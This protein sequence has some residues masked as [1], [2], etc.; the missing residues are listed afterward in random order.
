M[1]MDW[2]TPPR[3]VLKAGT[4]EVR[5]VREPDETG[6]GHA[7]DGSAPPVS[8]GEAQ[9]LP[10]FSVPLAVLAKRGP[11]ALGKAKRRGWRLLVDE[12][13]TVKLVDHINKTGVASMSSG[14]ALDHL[15]AAGEK[16]A[17]EIEADEA[18]YQPRVL[19][20]GRL[21]RSALWLHAPD[22][23]V[24]DRFF[25]VS[26]EPE[27]VSGADFLAEAA[28]QAQARLAAAGESDDSEIGG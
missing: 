17:R 1:P 20:F 6:G 19:E 28:E 13:G 7:A 8:P 21:G 10:L 3:G 2:S 4:A 27:E 22:P 18:T 16:A 5:A 23:E 15:L 12:G 14:S 11:E 24:K 25:T 26:A 9:A